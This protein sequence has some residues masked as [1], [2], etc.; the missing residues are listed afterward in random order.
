MNSKHGC[1]LL[2]ALL[3]GILFV[4]EYFREGKEE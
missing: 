3:N 2:Q 1:T 4:S